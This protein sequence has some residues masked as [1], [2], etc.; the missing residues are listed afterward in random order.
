ML[1]A[2]L[3]KIGEFAKQANENVSTI[4]HWVKLGLIDVTEITPAGY[5]LFSADTLN[6][7]KKIQSLKQKRFT[8]KEIMHKLEKD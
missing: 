1:D 6:R 8:L 7:I 5:Q 4:R 3:L 2:R